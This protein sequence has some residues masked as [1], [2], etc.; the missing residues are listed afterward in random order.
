MLDTTKLNNTSSFHINCCGIP[1]GCLKNRNLETKT[2]C[3]LAQL[4]G[5]A[6]STMFSEL[7]Y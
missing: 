1:T 6:S 7:D 4:Y 2:K 3:H 5:I